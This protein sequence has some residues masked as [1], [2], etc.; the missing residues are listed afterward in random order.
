[1]EAEVTPPKKKLK[2]ET[3]MIEELR[4]MS[5]RERNRARRKAKEALKNS[6]TSLFDSTSSKFHIVF[7][8]LESKAE[9]EMEEEQSGSD[10]EL[11][12]EWPFEALT[13]TL[14]HHLF[15]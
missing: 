6:S 11:P 9:N 12:N 15:E 7:Y 8:K 3:P 10:W 14:L 4:G 1:M 5:A 13:E 2:T